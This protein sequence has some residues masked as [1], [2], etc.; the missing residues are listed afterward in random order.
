MS[1]LR[2]S[3]EHTTRTGESTYIVYLFYCYV[4]ICWQTKILGLHICGNQECVSMGAG[5]LLNEH[6][7]NTRM[8]SARWNAMPKAKLDKRQRNCPQLVPMI[9]RHGFGV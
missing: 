9:H 1:C 3:A 8:P 6:R 7:Q 2:L 5:G 4:C